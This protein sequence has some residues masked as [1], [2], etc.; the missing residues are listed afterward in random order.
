MQELLYPGPKANEAELSARLKR[1]PI[2]EFRDA[3]HESMIAGSPH[4]TL[5]I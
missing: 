5:E 4:S 1:N 2:E 3:I